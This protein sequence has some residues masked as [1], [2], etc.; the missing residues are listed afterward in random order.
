MSS[1]EKHANNI[2][3]KTGK[4]LKS[5]YFPRNPTLEGRV[6]LCGFCLVLWEFFTKCLPSCLESQSF[7]CKNEYPW[8]ELL[9]SSSLIFMDPLRNNTPH[10]FQRLPVAYFSAYGSSIPLPW[11]Q[12][13]LQSQVCKSALAVST[14]TF[15]ESIFTELVKW[16]ICIP[17]ASYPEI[18]CLS[19]YILSFQNNS[20]LQRRC[21][22]KEVYWLWYISWFST[23]Y[24]YFSTLHEKPAH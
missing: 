12:H 20:R 14:M 9:V 8:I 3:C 17:P 6:C 4:T 16:K 5:R 2:C 21:K 23:S 22:Q 24:R 19:Q 18:H 1:S 11:L 10:G 7:D 13:H 15:R